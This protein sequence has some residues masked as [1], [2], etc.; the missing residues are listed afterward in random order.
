LSRTLAVAALT[1]LLLVLP[2]EPRRPTLPVLGLELTLLE[3]VA[4]AAVAVLLY[5]NRDRLGALLGRPP[6]PLAFL[7]SYVAAQFLSAA[8]APMNRVLAAKFAVRMAAAAA[9]ALAV[10]AT[11][12]E[13]LRRGLAALT[14]S[15]AVVAVLAILEGIGVT[16]LDPFLDRFRAGPFLIGTSRRASAGSENPN[17]AA[18][19]LLYGLVPAVGAATLRP[20]AARIVVPLTLLFSLGVLFTYSRG[21]LAALAVALATLGLALAARHR[22]TARA[23]AAAMATLLLA[24]VGFA[25]TGRSLRLPYPARVPPHAVRY[26]PGEAF[27]SLGP[28]EARTVP[29]TLT[30][31]GRRPWEAAVL[32]CSWQRA[33][34]ALAMDW[35]ATARCPIAPVPPAAPG[36]SVRVAA[37]I[38][39]PARE[40]RYLLVWDLVADGWVMSSAGVAPAT[41]PTIVSRTPTTAQP[42]SYSLPAAAWQR[43]RAA[44]WRAAAAMW[45]DHPITGVGPDNFRWAHAAYAGRPR[46]WQHETLIAANNMFLEAAATTGTLGLIALLGTFAATLRA[47]WRDLARV[48]AGSAQSVFPAVVLALTAAIA[49]HGA[50]DSFLGF[51]GHYLFLGFLVGAASSTDAA[52]ESAA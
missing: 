5:A 6:L 26:A 9:F 19:M 47:A 21:G 10:A 4:A 43:G 37:A 18:A 23:A 46:G 7:W 50:V 51:T 48:P 40:G 38:L 13:V 33:D 30:N 27:L 35:V 12:R 15:C 3:A 29:I 17:L 20:R 1:A 28:G 39:A 36:E 14:L 22:A 25:L 16:A 2:F 32:G 31:T 11:P 8:V 34:A 24:G 42:F 45:R 41:V 44:L 52:A 49:V